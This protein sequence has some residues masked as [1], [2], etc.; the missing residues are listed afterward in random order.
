MYMY[1]CIFL[2]MI[3]HA[4]VHAYV[5]VGKSQFQILFRPSPLY[6]WRQDVLLKLELV[7]QQLAPEITISVPQVPGLQVA[8]L[9]GGTLSV[10][11]TLQS[12]SYIYQ[13][14]TK[15]SFVIFF[16][17]YWLFR[18]FCTK[19]YILIIVDFTEHICCWSVIHFAAAVQ[20]I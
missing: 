11:S 12:V 5:F 10:E 1:A 4:C 15:D 19:Q 17:F 18:A 7:S 3:I 16:T 13:S 8:A 2:C 14:F 6:L 9:N 20:A